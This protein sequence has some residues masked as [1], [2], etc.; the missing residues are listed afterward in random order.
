MAFLVSGK[1]KAYDEN[2]SYYIKN[3]ECV[4]EG[5]LPAGARAVYRDISEPGIR[6]LREGEGVRELPRVYSIGSNIQN[7]NK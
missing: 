2:L 5:A 6:A 4:E 3:E 7:C 1:K